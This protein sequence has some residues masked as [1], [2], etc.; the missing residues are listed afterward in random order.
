VSDADRPGG[1][2]EQ[3]SEEQENQRDDEGEVARHS[4]TR[5]RLTPSGQA[6]GKLN[7]AARDSLSVPD[8]STVLTPNQAGDFDIEKHRA[9]QRAASA[10]FKQQQ[11]AAEA[12]HRRREETRMN[13]QRLLHERI[14]FVAFVSV[15][16]IV[17]VMALAAALFS[18]DGELKEWGR[19][20]V[21]LIVGGVVG[22]MAGYITGRSGI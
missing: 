6:S 8:T 15:L 2:T 13:S 20:L 9:E 21:V 17:L 19:S 14:M 18:D 5:P 10:V 11:E 3:R 4:P 22:G 1:P 16:A 7:R 12:E